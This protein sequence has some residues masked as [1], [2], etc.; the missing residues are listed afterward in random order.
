MCYGSEVWGFNKGKDIERAHL[1]FCKRILAVKQS[2]QNDF[3]YGELG[4]TSFQTKHYVNIIKY[5]I[6]I[7]EISD[8]KYVKIAY[9]ILL[10]DIQRFPNKTNWAFQVKLLLSELGFYEVW[11]NQSVGD[12]QFFISVFKQRLTDNFVQNWNAR[13]NDSSRALLYRNFN[14]FTFKPYL[15]IIKIENIRQPLT[16]LRTS[17]H[18]LEIEVGRWAKP[19]STPVAERLC[20][21]CHML[22]DEFHFVLQCVRYDDLRSQYITKHFYTRP[23]MYKFVKLM[24][25]SNES[26]LK[27]LALYVKKA[28]KVRAEYVFSVR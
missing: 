25:S 27:N 20:S 28:F 2:T 16:R 6:K 14:N 12:S 3:I 5:W 9:N 24:S 4:R 18:R 11:L 22:E 10:S 7:T 13:L 21:T 26:I 23:N 8:L 15:D 19:V 1:Q 17:S